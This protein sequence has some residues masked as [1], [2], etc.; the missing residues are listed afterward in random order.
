MYKQQEKTNAKGGDVLTTEQAAAHLQLSPSTLALW[1]RMGEPGLPFIRCGSR[2][3]RYL[4][5]DL[6]S[7]LYQNRIVLEGEE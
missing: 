5:T 1:R 3:I 6:D 2:R 4:K 7:F